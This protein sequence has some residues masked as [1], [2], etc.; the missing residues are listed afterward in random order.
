MGRELFGYGPVGGYPPLRKAIATHLATSRGV[1]CDP[2]QVIV[3]S[4]AQ[5]AFALS[6]LALLDQGDVAWGEHPGHTA[7]R[8]VVTALGATVVPVS[9]DAEGLDLNAGRAVAGSPKLIF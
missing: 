6:A 7:G 4:G 5:Q 9:I 8:D 1:N 2:G 3:T